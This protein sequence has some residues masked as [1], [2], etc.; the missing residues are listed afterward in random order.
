MQ[1]ETVVP[2][3][4]LTLTKSEII[5]TAKAVMAF[6]NGK[7]HRAMAIMKMQ[8]SRSREPIV[9]LLATNATTVSPGSQGEGKLAVFVTNKMMFIPVRLVVNVV[10][11]MSRTV[12][13]Q[14]AL[15]I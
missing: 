11:V 12:G 6:K 1:T 8:D 14:L 4:T 10:S 13:S 9:F 5:S 7:I 3:A 2:I 15:P